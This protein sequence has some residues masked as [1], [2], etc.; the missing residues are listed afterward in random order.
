MLFACA[1]TAALALRTLPAA[2]QQQELRIGIIAPVTGIFAQVGADMTNGFKMYL[3]QTNST[4]AG[5]KVVPIIEDSQAKPDLAVTKA[6]KLILQ[7]HV[8]MIVGGVLATEGYALAPVSTELKTVYI[9]SVTAADDLTQRQR[10]P[11]IVRMIWTSSQPGHP[12]SP[13]ST[14]AQAKATRNAEDSAAGR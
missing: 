6:R 4:F 3:D 8:Q 10:S 7:D 5:A 1:A 11:Y 12:S 13:S 2:A 9:S 14:T